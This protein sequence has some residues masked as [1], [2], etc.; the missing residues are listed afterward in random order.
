MTY[1]ERR[2]Y[3]PE[4]EMERVGDEKAANNAMAEEMLKAF[5]T[6]QVGVE[7]TDAASGAGGRAAVPG[8]RR[9]T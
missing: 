4:R 7:E 8:R 5:E 6:Q 3:D 1:L 2:G 9:A